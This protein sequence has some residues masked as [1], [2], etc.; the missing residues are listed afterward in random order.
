MFI[1]LCL[2]S[3]LSALIREW[4]QQ[5]IKGN[6]GSTEDVPMPHSPVPI[7]NFV[8]LAL[9]KFSKSQFPLVYNKNILVPKIYEYNKIYITYF[10]FKIF[11]IMT[12][13]NKC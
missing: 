6:K 9:L 5:G 7:L 10:N 12:M 13:F 8:G 1:F 2:C 3:E 4:L 11:T